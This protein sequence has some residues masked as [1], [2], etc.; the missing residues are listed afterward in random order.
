MASNSNQ[1]SEKQGMSTQKPETT[2]KELSE[3]ELS[4]VSGGFDPQPDPPAVIAKR[5][6]DFG[7]KSAKQ[8][9]SV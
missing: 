3:K 2:Q 8:A 5:I 1:G 6:L 4:Q 9:N 7:I